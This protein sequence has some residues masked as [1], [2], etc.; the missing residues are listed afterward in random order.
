MRQPQRPKP[1]WPRPVTVTASFSEPRKKGLSTYGGS[2]GFC[3]P[4]PGSIHP[5]TFFFLLACLLTNPA[6]SIHH[7]RWL[8]ESKLQLQQHSHPQL[9]YLTI[10]LRTFYISLGQ[11]HIRLPSQIFLHEYFQNL[12]CS[13]QRGPL[14]CVIPTPAT[15]CQPLTIHAATVRLDRDN[16]LLFT[17][18]NTHTMAL[19]RINKELTDLGRYAAPN[20]S[21]T[22]LL[23]RTASGGAEQWRRRGLDTAQRPRRPIAF[24]RRGPST[25]SKNARTS[26]SIVADFYS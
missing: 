13:E 3:G 15:P 26:R 19:K 23:I 20:P 4:L 2:S 18:P 24:D 17:Y 10:P 22:S 11:S 16:F 14:Q 6:S 1:Q 5:P 8:L 25:P 21:V 7:H 12:S 9:Q